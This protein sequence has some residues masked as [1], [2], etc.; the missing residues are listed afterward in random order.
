MSYVSIPN[1]YKEQDILLFKECYALE[2]IHGTSAHVAQGHEQLRYS[3]GG[4]SLHNFQALFDGD[5]LQER[6]ASLAREKVV[7]YGEAYG[8]KYQG[9]SNIYG[10]KLRFAVFDIKLDGMWLCVPD[11]D[12]LAREFGLEVVHWVKVPTTL[13]ALNAERDAPSVQAERNGCGTDKPREGI[14]IRP[15]I[16]LRKNNDERII[17][18]HKQDV[19][20]ERATPQKIVDPEKLK[21]LAEAGAIASEWVT[22]GRLANAKSHFTED[23]WCIENTRNIINYVTDDVIREA[24]AEIVVT[25]DVKRAVAKR[26]VQLFKKTL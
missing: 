8:G 24:G 7:V 20:S 3:P 5:A 6:M 25:K 16:E 19:F 10:K 1:L 2:K 17:A 21:V 11:M 14:V 4:E 22:L 18:K 26:T 15:L 9:M 12:Q 23:K 13:E